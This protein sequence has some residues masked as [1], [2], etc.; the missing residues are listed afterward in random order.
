[1]KSVKYQVASK[2]IIQKALLLTITSY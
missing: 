2:F 1:M